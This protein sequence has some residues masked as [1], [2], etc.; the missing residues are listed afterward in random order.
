MY[1]YDSFLLTGEKVEIFKD[2][3]VDLNEGKMDL[4]HMEYTQ[5]T[6]Y[7]HPLNAR[8]SD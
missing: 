7:N 6:N 3:F 1:R 2:T 4:D 5:N 8:M